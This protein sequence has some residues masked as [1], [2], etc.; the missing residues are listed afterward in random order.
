MENFGSEI[1]KRLERIEKAQA[2]IE[3][4]L[5]MLMQEKRCSV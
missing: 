3:R 1:V 4:K 5:S 2:R